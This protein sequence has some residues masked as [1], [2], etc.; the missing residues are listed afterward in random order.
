MPN[1]W[2]TL[3][4]PAGAPPPGTPGGPPR[5]LTL[6]RLMNLMVNPL[7]IRGGSAA[8]FQKDI[9]EYGSGAI[10]RNGYRDPFPIWMVADLSLGAMKTARGHFPIPRNFYLLSLF[11]SSSSNVKGGYKVVAYDTT[12]RMPFMLRPGNF[13]TLAGNGS[14]PLFMKVPY[15]IDGKEPKIKWTVA[16]L[17]SVTNNVQFGLYGFQVSQS[18][19]HRGY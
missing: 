6:P 1:L 15:P 7:A 8:N 13:N 19:D 11:A 3:F 16:S 9:Y 4:G 12:R 18:N 17:E 5:Q 10:L 14:S 2:D